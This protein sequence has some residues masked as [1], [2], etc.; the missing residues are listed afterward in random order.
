MP[1]AHQ[2]LVA[3]TQHLGLGVRNTSRQYSRVRGVH[4]HRCD[5]LAQPAPAKVFTFPSRAAPAIPGR[6]EARPA[7]PSAD[8]GDDDILDLDAGD[9]IDDGDDE[10][11][12]LGGD[13][14]LTTPVAAPP[15]DP[16]TDDDIGTT[17]APTASGGTLFE[18]MS[19]IAR[20]ASQAQIDEES[21]GYG[22][23]PIDIPRFLN[24]QNNQ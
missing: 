13:D 24:R 20:G 14:V 2:E 21:T 15:I 6:S 9:E 16:P 18:R 1:R 10:E 3:P 12:L 11:L 22:G 8:E 19:S 4:G 17:P 5:A 7:A 23:E